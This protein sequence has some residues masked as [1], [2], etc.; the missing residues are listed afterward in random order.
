MFFSFRRKGTAIVMEEEFY[1][2]AMVIS[3]AAECEGD[4]DRALR[5]AKTPAGMQITVR[6]SALALFTVS[7]EH[8]FLAVEKAE[9]FLESVAKLAGVH[10]AL[11]AQP[12]H[13]V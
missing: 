3:V 5:G 8:E 2:F 9:H 7:A 11:N 1:E 4:W 12:S 10:C 13:E 6:H